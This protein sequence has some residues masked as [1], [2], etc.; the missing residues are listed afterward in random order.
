MN[1][2]RNSRSESSCAMAPFSFLS[3][4]TASGGTFGCPS[5]I[6]RMSASAS[7][8]SGA[9][10]SS[11]ACMPSPH[12]LAKRSV[13]Y[14]PRLYATEPAFVAPAPPSVVV[15]SSGGRDISA[16]PAKVRRG[17][18][19]VVESQA[20][21]ARGVSEEEAARPGAA[22][23]AILRP[24]SEDRQNKSAGRS[25][26]TR[27][28]AALLVVC[29]GA[30]DGAVQEPAEA[31]LDQREDRRPVVRAFLACTRA[32]RAGRDE[33]AI[34]K[35]LDQPEGA[36]RIPKNREVARARMVR[37]IWSAGPRVG[38]GAGEWSEVLAVPLAPVGGRRHRDQCQSRFDY[39]HNQQT[40][41]LALLQELARI[42]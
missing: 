35:V 7:A 24:W 23:A 40:F 1:L 22:Y 42:C 9:V 4:A 10:V 29:R 41:H 34:A 26:R 6:G 37:P 31:A 20:R 18:D 2:P 33:F 14:V 3:R 39:R 17:I 12:P 32:L 36:I 13:F 30:G 8:F 5:K 16:V 19:P 27:R 25:A 15:S 21:V 11:R 38:R 28:V